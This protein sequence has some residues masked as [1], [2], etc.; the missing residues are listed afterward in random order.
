MFISFTRKAVRV[1]PRDRGTAWRFATMLG[2]VL[3]A[4]SLLTAASAL[5]QTTSTIQGTVTDKQGL[6][7]N[8]AE[9]RL[10]SNATAATQTV[11]SDDE[12]NYQFAAVTAGYQNSKV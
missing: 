1:A 6:A 9:L 7:V 4:C 12:G 10:T 3:G 5:A 2:A 11:K 8:Q